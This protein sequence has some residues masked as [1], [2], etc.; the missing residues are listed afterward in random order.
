MPR[1]QGEVTREGV[2]KAAWIVGLGFVGLCVFWILSIMGLFPLTYHEVQTFDELVDFLDS[3]RDD[4]RGIKVNGHLLEIGK[5]PSLQVLP[6]Y[7]EHLYLVRPYRKVTLKPRNLTRY[8]V[9]DLCLNISG[10]ELERRREES[11][12]GRGGLPVWSGTLAGRP[13]AIQRVSMFTYLVSGLDNKTLLI[14]QLELA[15]RIGMPDGLILSRIVSTQKAWYAS[16]TVR[17]GGSIGLKHTHLPS[18]R[19]ALIDWLQKT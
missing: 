7:T 14:S 18:I 11:R 3:P 2:S 8:E 10:E 4:R 5:R 16:L 17:Q 19:D 1:I 6:G 15:K 13:V 12:T 9:V